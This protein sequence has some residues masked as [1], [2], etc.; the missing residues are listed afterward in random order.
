MYRIVKV[1]SPYGDLPDSIDFYLTEC[2]LWSSNENL[3][4]IWDHRADPQERVR[5]LNN[6]ADK[7]FDINPYKKFQITTYFVEEV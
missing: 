5:D 3:A 7:H 1:V 4:R 6:K 2:G